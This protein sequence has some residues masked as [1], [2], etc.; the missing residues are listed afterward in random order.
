MT[1]FKGLR[2]VVLV[3]ENLGVKL[4]FLAFWLVVQ[5]LCLA[6]KAIRKRFFILLIRNFPHQFHS[7]ICEPFCFIIKQ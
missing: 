4:K 1:R 2:F 5:G 6:R 7:L 3:V